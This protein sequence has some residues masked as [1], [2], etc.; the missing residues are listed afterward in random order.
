M[1]IT[2]H[3]RKDVK[4]VISATDAF[5]TIT[6]QFTFLINLLSYQTMRI[7]LEQDENFVNNILKFNLKEVTSDF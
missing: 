6:F 5:C 3:F 4:D 7:M 1:P 2:G